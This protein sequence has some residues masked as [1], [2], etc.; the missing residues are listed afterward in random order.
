MKD[1]EAKL[2]ALEKHNKDIMLMLEERFELQKEV[3]T[4]IAAYL[5]DR[6]YPCHVTD[7]NNV[8]I[9]EDSVKNITYEL[10]ELLFDHVPSS[11]TPISRRQPG[12]GTLILLQNLSEFRKLEL[13]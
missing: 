5:E 9:H 12:F 11:K 2:A 8:N 4:E 13:D 3:A 1:L 10:G 6:D 7:E